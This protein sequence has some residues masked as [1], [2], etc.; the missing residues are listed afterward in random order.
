MWGSSLLKNR[1]ERSF[2][3]LRMWTLFASALFENEK[4]HRFLGRSR[5]TKRRPNI[6]VSFFCGDVLLGKQYSRKKGADGGQLRAKWEIYCSSLTSC[7]ETP[8]KIF[9]FKEKI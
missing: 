6:C 3:S 1:L 8:I 5:P 4:G 7:S 9:C 2:S